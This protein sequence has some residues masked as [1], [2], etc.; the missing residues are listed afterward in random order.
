MKS[1]PKP[2]AK[3]ASKPAPKPAPKA[4]K[5]RKPKGTFE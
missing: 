5:P 2:A 4:D 3:P 1:K